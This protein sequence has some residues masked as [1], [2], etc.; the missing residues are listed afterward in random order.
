M[1]TTPISGDV[2]PDFLAVHDVGDV[3][4]TNAKL[5]RQR[6][7]ATSGHA[8]AI[9]LAYLAY[10]ISIQLRRCAVVIRP[11][12][13][14]LLGNHVG[15]V[16]VVRAKL[17]MLWP[18]AR[19]IVAAVHYPKVRRDWADVDPVGNAVRPTGFA[20]AVSNRSIPPL[21]KAPRCPHPTL[22]KIWAVLWDRPI[23]IDLRPKPFFQWPSAH[24]GSTTTNRIAVPQ[25]AHVVARTQPARLQQGGATINGAWRDLSSLHTQVYNRGN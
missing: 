8:R 1:P 9:P 14:A 21:I 11:A 2:Q 16:L 4:G 12:L 25:P 10:L 15:H 18:D 20:V 19:G 7:P 24:S 6:P 13:N 22:T 17:Q 23:L 5:R 3:G